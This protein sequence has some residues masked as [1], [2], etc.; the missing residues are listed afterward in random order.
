M[1]E[2]RIMEREWPTWPEDWMSQGNRYMNSYVEGMPDW[3][4]ECSS[5]TPHP[6]Y[7]RPEWSSEYEAGYRYYVLKW[8]TLDFEKRTVEFYKDPFEAQKAFEKARDPLRKHA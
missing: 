1:R 4:V 8:N 2:R 5:F 3:A 7:G 6:L